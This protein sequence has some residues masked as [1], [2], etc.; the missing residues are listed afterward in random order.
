MN[1][2]VC[3]FAYHYLNQAKHEHIFMVCSQQKSVCVKGSVFLSH[4]TWI[5]FY[6]LKNK[7]IYDQK[8]LSQNAHPWSANP[9]F[10]RKCHNHSSLGFSKLN[11]CTFQKQIE[12]SKWTVL[13]KIEVL[14]HNGRGFRFIPWQWRGNA[15]NHTPSVSNIFCS[16]CNG[17]ESSWNS[18]CVCWGGGGEASKISVTKT[19]GVLK[20][21]VSVTHWKCTKIDSWQQWYCLFHRHVRIL[22]R[23][24][25][26]E[27]QGDIQIN[28]RINQYWN[29]C[30]QMKCW[31]M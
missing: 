5:Y 29:A 12:K 18:V 19:V 8:Q 23:L 21:L 17:S 27:M 16:S 1:N 14:Q 9:L 10:I 24:W 15:F 31:A 28:K 6:F 2:T 7:D 30:G 3:Q 26:D 13:R 25:S 11:T 20:L 22:T 4:S